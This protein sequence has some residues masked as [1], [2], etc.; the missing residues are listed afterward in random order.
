MNNQVTIAKE[1]YQE[2][3]EKAHRFEIIQKLAFDAED[4]FQE[5]V[6]RNMSAII[7]AMGKTGRY[8]K[9]FLKSLEGGLKKSPYF[10]K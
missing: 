6:T 7:R 9:S 1:K 2:L 10:S 8:S 3:L 4:F 5:P